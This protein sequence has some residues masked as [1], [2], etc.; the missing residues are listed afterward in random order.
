MS[1]NIFG[2]KLQ[3]G[4]HYMTLW[5][6]RP[7]LNSMFP[8]NR[9]IKATE[10]ALRVIPA[11]AV[12]SVM[13]QF[14]FGELHYWPSVMASVLFLL[15]LPLQ[16]YYWLANWYREINGK[17]NE[18]GGHRQLVARPRYEELADTLNA[19]FKQLDKSFLY[20]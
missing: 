7:E 14:Q 12:L 19:A 17:M 6:R 9:V 13:L 11:L 3:Q 8:E 4:R 18:Q 2:T 1:M 5:P 16:G 15:S 10:F 20:E